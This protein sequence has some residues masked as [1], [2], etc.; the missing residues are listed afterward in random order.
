MATQRGPASPTPESI[1]SYVTKNADSVRK[2]QSH[3]HETM[4]SVR[5]ADYQGHHIIVRTHYEIEVDGKKVLGHVGVT[6]DG[7]V[8]YHPVPNLSFA[9]AVEMVEKLIDIFPEDFTKNGRSEA[10]HR[11]SATL[12]KTGK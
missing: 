3:A 2:V 7:Q 10:G 4:P 1:A 9:S 6:N 11:K 12:K 5:E 8:H